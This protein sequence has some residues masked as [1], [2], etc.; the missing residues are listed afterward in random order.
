[1]EDQSYSDII[2]EFLDKNPDKKDIINWK[3][4]SKKNL[5]IT[6]IDNYCDY[7]DWDMISSHY[8]FN[9]DTINKFDNFIN[10]NLLSYNKNLTEDIILYK[11][12]KMDWDILQANQKLS[13]AFILKF[14]SMLNYSL[15]IKYQKLEEDTIWIL[16]QDIIDNKQWVELKNALDL[17]FIF[18][19]MSEKLILYF[20]KLDCP[21]V[22]LVDMY[23]V[24][25]HQ[26]LS[27]D[28]ITNIE[29][30]MEKNMEDN[31]ENNIELLKCIYRYQKLS[32]NYISKIKEI[33]PFIKKLLTYQKISEDLFVSLF[34]P[35]VIKYDSLILR[36]VTYQNFT[37]EF[38]DNF[39]GSVKYSRTEIEFN[40]LLGNLYQVIFTKYL[41]KVSSSSLDTWDINKII[42]KVNWDSLV[43][44]EL[45]PIIVNELLDKYI[46]KISL[47]D[48]IK[49][50]RLEESTILKLESKKLISLFE[51]WLILA[52]Y[53][54]SVNFTTKYNNYK[55]WWT[56]NNINFYIICQDVFNKPNLGKTGKYIKI[57]LDDFV[58]LTNWDYLIRYEQLNEN[59]IDLFSRY[60]EKINLFWWKICRYQKLSEDF[61]RKNILNLDIEI[62]ISYQELSPEYIEELTPFLNNDFW[63]I[64]YKSRKIN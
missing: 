30:N 10:N 45:S 16:L 33:R 15:I 50:N 46:D 55:K 12:D 26:D 11:L 2:S 57:F 22:N 40:K 54:Y 34:I 47:Y 35:H 51:W 20:T 6:F 56:R 17:I 5:S 9:M 18:Q 41:Y 58:E 31:M 60:S 14:K 23:L 21:V 28:F 7:I 24:V 49:H 38:F 43:L 25:Q 27:I 53:K 62:I 39:M 59:F 61:I 48:L 37:E 36:W 44:Q 4:L 8:K 3:E 52:K 42:D 64:I 29:N 1:M 13:N 19:H 63:D 32:D